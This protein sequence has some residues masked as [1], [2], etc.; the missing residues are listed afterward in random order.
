MYMA[1][2]LGDKM[3]PCLTLFEIVK[4]LEVD[5]PHLTHNCCIWYQNTII[6]TIRSDIVL[7]ISYVDNVQWLRD[8][9]PCARQENMGTLECCV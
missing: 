4:K 3:S 6:R 7:S 8:Q 2:S 9:K 5:P 1:N